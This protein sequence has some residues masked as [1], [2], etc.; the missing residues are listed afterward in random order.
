MRSDPLR[1]GVRGALNG[2]FQLDH[3]HYWPRLPRRSASAPENPGASVVLQ[4]LY[5]APPT[6]QMDK[7]L[8][9]D[10]FTNFNPAPIVPGPVPTALQLL[11]HVPA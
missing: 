4:L 6:A 8:S 11:T 10:V 3:H 1:T 5:D 2:D 9:P 7:P